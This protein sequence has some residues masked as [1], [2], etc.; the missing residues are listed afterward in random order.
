MD[1]SDEDLLFPR[2]KSLK[3]NC[4]EKSKSLANNINR[5]YNIAVSTGIGISRKEKLR[6]NILNV[7]I[8]LFS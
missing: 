3:Y 8:S 7:I 5:Y 1:H 4:Q 6:K 2:L